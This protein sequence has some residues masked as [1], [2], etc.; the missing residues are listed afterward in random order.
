MVLIVL[1]GCAG[2][3]SNEDLQRHGGGGQACT[4]PD[5]PTISFASNIQPIFDVSC[6]LASCHTGAVPAENLD[7]TSGTARRALVGV[8]S[9]Q[10]PGQDRVVSGDPAASYLVQKIEGTS[11]IAGQLMPLGCPGSPQAG[12][13]C[14][15]GDQI[16]A[17]KTWISECA[18]AN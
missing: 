2:G 18:P 12:A 1:A 8:P 14:L 9:T 7:L 10:M 17:I 15:T 6:A 4:P 3:G 16:D 13:V 5:M 11:G